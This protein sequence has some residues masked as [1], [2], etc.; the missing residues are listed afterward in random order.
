MSIQKVP[1]TFGLTS[2]Q[3]D[4]QKADTNPGL[5]AC[6]RAPLT[7]FATLKVLVAGSP[8]ED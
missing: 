1:R 7:R 4:W 5:S 3:F 8:G 6:R 2:P